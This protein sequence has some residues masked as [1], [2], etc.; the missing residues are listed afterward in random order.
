MKRVS[1][2]SCYLKNMEVMPLQND[3]KDMSK[4]DNR[5]LPN[6]EI[7]DN[8]QTSLVEHCLMDAFIK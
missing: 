7:K 5:H 6:L 2:C 1:F 3:Y 8:Q 4:L